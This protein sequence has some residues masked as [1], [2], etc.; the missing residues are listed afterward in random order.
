MGILFQDVVKAFHK[1][2]HESL[3]SKL[4]HLGF[5]AHLIK[6]VNNYLNT[7]SFSNR[8]ENS[9]PSTRPIKSDFQQ[10]VLLWPLLFDLYVNDIPQTDS[11]HLVTYADGRNSFETGSENFLP[12]SPLL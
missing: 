6:S 7:C 2:W 5:S 12:P 3:I 8:E 9:F 11:S 1:I 4:V 10:G